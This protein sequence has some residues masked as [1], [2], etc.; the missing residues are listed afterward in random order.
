MLAYASCHNFIKASMEASDK[1]VQHILT[2]KKSGGTIFGSDNRM[3][4]IINNP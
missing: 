2:I 1:G 3:Y 4:A